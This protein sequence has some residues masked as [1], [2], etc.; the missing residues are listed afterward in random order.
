[1][2]LYAIGDVQGCFRTLERLLR[3]IRFDSVKDRLWMAGDLV[4]RGP[5][6]LEV[7]RWARSLDSSLVCVLG[8]HDLHL[9]GRALGLRRAKR[10]DTLDEILEAPDQHELLEWL[11]SRPLL[12]REGGRL[13]VHAGLQ[14]GWT[15]ADAE[16]VARAL[17]KRLRGRGAK[18]LIG[19][20]SRRG[21]LGWEEA[22]EGEERDVLALQTLTLMRTCDV[23]GRLCHEFSGPPEDAP[24]AC[25]PWFA[26]PER[27]AAD[28]QVVCGHWAALGLRQEPHLVALDTG[29][30]WGGPLSA[31]RLDDG[32][33][34][35]E[36]FAD[37]P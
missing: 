1:V 10:L 8:N 4:N 26:I 30:V 35:Q 19:S 11:R 32:T 15:V 29:C 13:L 27:R 17:E 12:H 21:L 24:P 25:R 34:F 23:D 18:A 6:S 31:V 22:R 14:P 2:A 33:L 20:L 3:R 16:T 5:R 36:P 7:L 9:I 37:G 28:T